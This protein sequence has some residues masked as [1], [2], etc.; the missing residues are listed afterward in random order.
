MLRRS[1]DSASCLY[2]RRSNGD[3][4]C[5]EASDEGLALTADLSHKITF[6][7]TKYN[8]HKDIIKIL[9][10]LKYSW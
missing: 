8:T 3:L 10:S 4:G 5:G 6:T 2:L 9:N 1:R 7:L